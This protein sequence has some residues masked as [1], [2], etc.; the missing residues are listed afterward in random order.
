[1]LLLKPHGRAPNAYMDVELLK[2]DWDD[3]L[4]HER[5]AL[6]A[7]DR[8]AALSCEDRIHT[9]AVEAHADAWVWMALRGRQELGLTI[10][11]FTPSMAFMTY[12]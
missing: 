11:H 1:M 9:G 12:A 10:H 5:E 3:L 4:G 7:L 8:R 6:Q 2:L